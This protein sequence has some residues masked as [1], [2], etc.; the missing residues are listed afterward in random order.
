M[1]N[2]GIVLLITGFLLLVLDEWVIKFLGVLSLVFGI[3]AV[4][5]PVKMSEIVA[6]IALKFSS[7]SST[8]K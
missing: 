4:L 3:L 2:F 6:E 7:R 8:K 1:R 5:I